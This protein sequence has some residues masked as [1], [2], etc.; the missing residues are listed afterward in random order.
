M[1]FVDIIL[2]ACMC[3]MCSAYGDTHREDIGHSLPCYIEAG[4]LTD[5]G[6]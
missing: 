6:E 4:S 3:G 5:S 1:Q 2:L